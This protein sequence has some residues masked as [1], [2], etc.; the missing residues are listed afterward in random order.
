MTSQVTIRYFEGCPSWRAALD[1]LEAA[2][3]QGR[4][5]AAA[6]DGR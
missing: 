5:L 6:R 4:Y 1:H 2:A 3:A